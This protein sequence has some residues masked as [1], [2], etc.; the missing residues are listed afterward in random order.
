MHAVVEHIDRHLDQKLDLARWPASRISP[1]FHFHR[2]FHALM[3]EALGD[4]LR[5]RRLEIA[6][7]AAARP[8]ARCRCC[9]IALGVGFGS[10]EA[11]TRAFRAASAARPPQWRNSKHDQ[12][13]RKPD[14][15]PATR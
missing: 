4:Y 15:A 2:L 9:D 12:M 8:A 13:A 14:Q 7:I 3:G 5:R 1:P 10:A 6:A 11:F